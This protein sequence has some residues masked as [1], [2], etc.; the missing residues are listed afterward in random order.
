MSRLSKCC[1][2]AHR[3]LRHAVFELKS[4]TLFKEERSSR[5]CR[6]SEE[7]PSAKTSIISA[8][9][10]ASRY[11]SREGKMLVP[12]QVPLLGATANSRFRV[13][14]SRTKWGSEFVA[15]CT[16]YGL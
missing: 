7:R 14:G 2:L 11:G 9:S 16:M 1:C 15:Y 13:V 3:S 8:T 12:I 10:V 4:R 5:K 6:K